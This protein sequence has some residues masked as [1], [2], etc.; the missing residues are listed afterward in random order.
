MKTPVRLP[1]SVGRGRCPA[2]SSA[3]CT[4]SSSM[5]CWGSISAA[6]RGEMP[7]YR[8]SK[9]RMSSTRPGMTRV[10]HAAGANIGMV[11]MGKRPAVVAESD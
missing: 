9:A 8:A 1:A 2:S 7:K 3:S 11:E 6:S 5:R 4:T 10:V